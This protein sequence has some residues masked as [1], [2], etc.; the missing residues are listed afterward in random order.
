MTIKAIVLLLAFCGAAFAQ[1]RFK[2]DRFAIGYW[3][4]PH[5][6]E[7]LRERYRE[8]AEANFTLVIGS[9]GMDIKTQ[10]GRIGL[11]FGRYAHR[12]GSRNIQHNSPLSHV[13]DPATE[14]SSRL[15]E[16]FSVSHAEPGHRPVFY[17]CGDAEVLGQEA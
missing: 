2:Q 14:G 4:G 1:E 6:S 7:N 8:I 3:V 9:H 17:H 15:L 5:T 12:I 10:F 11:L 13:R 16:A